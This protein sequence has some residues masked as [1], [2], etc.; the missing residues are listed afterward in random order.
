[1]ADLGEPVKPCRYNPPSPFPLGR[2]RLCD[3]ADTGC[4]VCGAQSEPGRGAGHEYD[5]Q[6][7][8]QHERVARGIVRC[9]WQH[10]RQ[11][12]HTGSFSA[13]KGNSTGNSTTNV[14]TTVSAGNNL[15]LTSGNNT[16][17]SGAVASGNTVDAN[18]G[19]NLLI[20][21]LQDTASYTSSQKQ[22]GVNGGVQFSATSPNP[23]SVSANVSDSNVNANFNERWHAEWDRGWQW[24]VQR[25]RRREHKPRR[26]A[27]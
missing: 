21:S 5:Y 7:E 13:G 6:D 9:G 22:V 2:R 12:R 25:Q 17:L 8:Q 3:P 11:C 16:T 18:V 20:Q 23:W 27:D 19:G 1:M 10:W 24:R 14:N 4:V 15:T 26:R